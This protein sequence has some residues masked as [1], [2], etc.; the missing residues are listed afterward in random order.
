MEASARSS[1]HTAIHTTPPAYLRLFG[2]RQE[3]AH[4]EQMVAPI[5][6]EI[7]LRACEIAKHGYPTENYSA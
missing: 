3:K 2:G 1:A 4:C 7:I 5:F 6:S